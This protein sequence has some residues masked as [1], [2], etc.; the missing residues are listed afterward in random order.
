MA[1]Q[2]GSVPTYFVFNG[3]TRHIEYAAGNLP[4]FM[5]GDEVHFDLMS[6]TPTDP[7]R[8]IDISGVWVVNSRKLTFGGKRDGLTQYIEWSK[9]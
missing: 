4:L 2:M 6:R 9:I 1:S 5:V 8:P 3:L 7:K